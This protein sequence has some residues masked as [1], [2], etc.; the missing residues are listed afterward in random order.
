VKGSPYELRGRCCLREYRKRAGVP[1]TSGICASRV[2]KGCSSGH[3]RERGVEISSH[4]EALRLIE[5][6]RGKLA[7]HGKTSCRIFNDL[8]MLRRI[9]QQGGGGMNV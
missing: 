3:S 8:R 2:S 4:V 7:S 5:Y 6:N 1:R 9:L